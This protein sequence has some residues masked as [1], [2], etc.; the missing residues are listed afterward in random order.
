MPATSETTI[1][2]HGVTKN[3]GTPPQLVRALR[4]VELEIQRDEIVV[5]LGP[6]GSGKTTLLNVVGGIEAPT[7]GSVVVGGRAV[8]ELDEE[9]RA[10]FRREHVGFVFQFFN[11]I[12]T[13]SITENVQ[14]IAELRSDIGD[15]EERTRR[16]LTDLG[17]GEQLHRYPAQLSGGQQQR[18]AVARALVNEPAVLLCD[19]P[20]GALDLETGRSILQL[21][22]QAQRERGATVLVVTHNS[23]I[24]KMADRVLNM[25]SGEI[26]GDRRIEDPVLPEEVAW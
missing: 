18:V 1:E 16:T 7:E 19:E 22:R 6:S 11:L 13:L 9:A 21:L 25:R 26:V 5:L 12:P 14:L 23:A 17:L 20:T 4:G 2:L 15:P 10:D 24:A 3:Y 8:E